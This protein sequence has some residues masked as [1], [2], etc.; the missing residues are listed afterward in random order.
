VQLNA[1]ELERQGG[2]DEE[3]RERQLIEYCEAE[4]RR[5]QEVDVLQDVFHIATDQKTGRF[6][7]INT[8]RLGRL[9]GVTVDWVEI[10]AALGQVALLLHTAARALGI[11]FSAHALYPMGSFSKVAQLDDP[12]HTLYE[13]HGSGS[14][15][16]GRLFGN[17]RFDKGL[18]MLLACAKDVLAFANA[19]PRAGAP[20]PSAPWPI[21]D[22][23][24]GGFSVQLH[25]NHEDKWTCAFKNLLENLKWLLEWHAA[26]R[27]GADAFSRMCLS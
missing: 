22:D 11:A 20:S 5:L 17:G 2:E 19:R 26:G 15:P 21:E 25:F 4:L 9:P 1:A 24:V 23:L 10:N 18:T 8:L 14:A 16:L 3:L 12:H 13:L 27:D 7:T 6:G